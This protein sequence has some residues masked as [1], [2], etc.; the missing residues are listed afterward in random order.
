MFKNWV[1][2]D[3]SIV[4]AS[5]NYLGDHHNVQKLGFVVYIDLLIVLASNN[6]LGD[7]HDVQKLGFVVEHELQF[8]RR[9]DRRA[10]VQ[11]RCHK[12]L[13][14]VP[15]HIL[16]KAPSNLSYNTAHAHSV[17]RN[18]PYSHTTRAPSGQTHPTQPPDSSTLHGPHRTKT[19]HRQ[20]GCRSIL[21]SRLKRSSQVV[22]V[23]TGTDK[24]R[25]PEPPTR[26]A[27]PWS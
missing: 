6:Y 1:C 22:R 14:A 16:Q 5:N 8:S 9:H 13:K 21:P 3:L 7:H 27:S 23:R 17:V 12:R 10:T 11:R 26:R 19:S 4:L 18:C 2:I 24:R 25:V 20:R 15:P